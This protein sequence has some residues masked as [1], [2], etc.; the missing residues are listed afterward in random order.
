MNSNEFVDYYEIL[1]VSRNAANTTI[2]RIFRYFGQCLHPDNSDTGDDA[3]F[4]QLLDAYA[5][6]R[7][8]Q[9]RAAYDA[10]YRA[11]QEGRAE[12]VRGAGAVSSDN[13][14]RHRLLSM[15]YGQ[16]RRDM[17]HPGVG[18]ATLEKVL[19]C[20]SE[21]LEFHLWYFREK[22]WI[23]REETGLF[24]ITIEGIDRIEADG[25]RM[26]PANRA[27]T[28]QSPADN[29]TANAGRI[30]AQPPR[31]PHSLNRRTISS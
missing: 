30:P 29:I 7:D 25:Q 5:T 22:Q 11:E 14:D 16:R 1:Q 6:L 2:E 15:F 27:I 28:M 3:K 13:D 8:P 9:K 12:I 20:P 31:P 24:A 10:R 23:R 4:R 21:V 26:T 17:K 18:I 19:G